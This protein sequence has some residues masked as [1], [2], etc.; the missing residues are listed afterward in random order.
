[1][2]QD[3]LGTQILIKRV[4]GGGGEK[5]KPPLLKLNITFPWAFSLD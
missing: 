3:R 4:G 1:M 5:K 2:V